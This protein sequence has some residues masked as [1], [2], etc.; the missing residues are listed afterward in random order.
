MESFT[1]LFSYAAQFS[2]YVI[3]V[4]SFHESSTELSWLDVSLDYHDS[5]A[6]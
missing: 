1:Q 5:S 2:I 4:R 6:S 3:L